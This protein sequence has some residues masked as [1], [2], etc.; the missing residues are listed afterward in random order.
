MDQ[1]VVQFDENYA[2]ELQQ[3]F[4]EEYQLE[5][6]EEKQSHKFP[7][8]IGNFVV[9]LLDDLWNN[10]N[11]KVVDDTFSDDCVSRGPFGET[12]GRNEFKNKVAL[13]LFNA[14]P[15][16]KYVSHEVYQDGRRMVNRWTFSGT[17]TGA[18]YDNYPPLGNKVAYSG[19][20]INRF[21]E[22][23]KLCEI[24]TFFDRLA[25]HEQLQQQKK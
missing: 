14:F 10:K 3:Q 17:H 4:D 13:P 2:K 9:Q 24:H 19:V 8:G 12:V 11:F 25:V 6:E 7:T 18:M 21:N 22:D 16:L 1:A 23:N 15:D 20:T 5:V